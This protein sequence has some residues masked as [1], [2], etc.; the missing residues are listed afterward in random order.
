MYLSIVDEHDLE[1]LHEAIGAAIEEATERD[2]ELT[3]TDL[4]VRL[5]DAYVLGERDPQKLVE[6]VLFSS[7]KYVH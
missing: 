3:V 5:F 4:T 7:V 6:A 2:I 1:L